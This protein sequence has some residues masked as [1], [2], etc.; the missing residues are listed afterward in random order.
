[1]K[2]D[3]IMLKLTAAAAAWIVAAGLAFAATQPP[4]FTATRGEVARAV[5]SSCGQS[6]PGC[7]STVRTWLAAAATC[8]D[9]AGQTQA[10]ICSRQILDI[11]RGLGDA[12]LFI[13]STDASLFGMIAAAVTDGAPGCFAGAF[14]QIAQQ[15]DE[16]PGTV[17]SPG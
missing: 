4:D 10:C 12:A 13:R 16:D 3:R 6:E 17:G 1:M 5:T 15:D 2:E 11:A 9:Q 8:S 7:L 14:S